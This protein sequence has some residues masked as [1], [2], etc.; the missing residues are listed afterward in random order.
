MEFLTSGEFIQALKDYHNIEE[1]KKIAEA[2]YDRLC[3][4]RY[5]KVKSPLDYDIVG[6]DKKGNAL[7]QI[8][9]RSIASSEQ[10]ADSNDAL[11]KK[12]EQCS[13]KI[14]QYR[15]ILLKT[16]VELAAIGMPLKKILIVRYK[17]HSKL[18]KV[19]NAFSELCLDESGMYK[20]IK[21]ELEKY[22]TLS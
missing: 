19:C 4:L 5:E 16:D 9:G 22:Y 3:Y 14:S 18:K 6:Y 7:R 10:I 12:M 17:E 11:D 21:R 13:K 20:Y 1:R 2:E 15:D 8:K